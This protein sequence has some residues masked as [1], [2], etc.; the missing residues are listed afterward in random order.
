MNVQEAR[1]EWQADKAMLAGNGVVLPGVTMD[2]PDDWKRDFRMAMDAH[3]AVLLDWKRDFR[4]AMDAQPTLS[5]DPSSA[6]PALLT[7]VIDPT[8]IRLVFTPLQFAKILGERKA[9]DWLEET[10]IF[11]VVE[12]TGEV[13]SY[14]DFNNNGRAGVNLN[15]PNFQS[16][17][18]QTFVRYGERELE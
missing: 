16:Y 3:A 13:S 7:T 1:S 10:R 14:G 2:M 11:P 5:T 9:G 17:L 6:I 12:E 18:F 4:M 15:F 8:V